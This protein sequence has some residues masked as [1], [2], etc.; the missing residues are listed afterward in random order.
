MPR[1][2]T[3]DTQPV[4]TTA[5]PGA[6]QS[7][8]LPDG[9]FESTTTRIAGNLF[10][11]AQQYALKAQDDADDTAVL[12]ARTA[13]AD[14][15]M[16]RTLGDDENGIQG[17][18]KVTV[19]ERMDPKGDKRPLAIR[20]G[21]DFD[22]D[23][24]EIQ[25]GLT[26]RQQEKFAKFAP[27]LSQSFKQK[28]AEWDN[29]LLE[30]HKDSV[31]EA[32]VLTASQAIAAVPS[33]TDP[34]FREAISLLDEANRQK[35]GDGMSAEE[36]AVVQATGRSRALAAKVGLALDAE[37]S[38]TAV[39]FMNA[40]TPEGELL[41]LPADREKLK[42]KVEDSASRTLGKEQFASA[43]ARGLGQAE[44]LAE[45]RSF[46]P[47]DDPA[48]VRS[49]QLQE[50]EVKRAFAKK[51]SEDRQERADASREVLDVI[52]SGGQ[53]TRAQWERMDP[54]SAR[55]AEK[56]Q[57]RLLYGLDEITDPQVDIQLEEL[58]LT[59][60]TAYASVD[61][62]SP[63]LKGLG[64]KERKAHALAALKMRN[65]KTAKGESLVDSWIKDDMARYKPGAFAKKSKGELPTSQK[66]FAS[67]ARE[68]VNA[69][70]EENGG[71]YPTREQYDGIIV[72]T[73]SKVEQRK[74]DEGWYD[75]FE[76]WATGTD[77]VKTF[78]SGTGEAES[79]F[80]ARITRRLEEQGKD[81]KDAL[82]RNRILVEILAKGRGGQTSGAP[83]VGV[84][85]ALR[86][87]GVSGK[88]PKS[89]L[90]GQNGV[91]LRDQGALQIV[92]PTE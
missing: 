54:N 74:A 66:G 37:D 58:R 3:Y 22:N 10:D 63:D 69:W 81:P 38:R 45:L 46:L 48:T 13:A 77:D 20:F 26:P 7:I 34:A 56:E 12:A 25:K 6:R 53:P 23:L 35:F 70:S 49:R 8:A 24:S 52:R 64:A 29:Q 87:P 42:S 11:K 27:G 18:S 32:G 50:D 79:I 88:P 59:N 44:A 91:A 86:N 57:K 31:A 62:F 47:G 83:R 28:A 76:A 40:T 89:N 72:K 41:L 4:A 19:P 68:A 61:L 17:F 82:E 30:K 2:P 71:A 14:K 16:R 51:D 33:P 73:V 90:A 85:P 15:A 1:I 21:A 5:L 9:A 75:N 80:G 36:L 78:V 43:Q 65:P 67:F 60:P 39:D 84:T 92:M 55:E